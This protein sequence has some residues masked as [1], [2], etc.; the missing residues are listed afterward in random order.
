MC[1]FKVY[2]DR[3]MLH[4][5]LYCFRFVEV[6]DKGLKLNG[7]EGF[8]PCRLVDETKL[9]VLFI[10]NE[11]K[12]IRVSKYVPVLE[13]LALLGGSYDSYIEEEIPKGCTDVNR[14]ANFLK[15]G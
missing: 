12:I 5:E 9:I 2:Y 14:I 11:K 3:E 13:A 7:Y 8:S 4:K 6:D 1:R 10:G 15:A